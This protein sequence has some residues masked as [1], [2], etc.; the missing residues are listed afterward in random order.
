MENIEKYNNAFMEVF[1]V[2]AERLND[3]FVNKNVDNWDSVHHLA[4]CSMVEESFDIMLDT[5]DLLA[6]TSYVK[7]KEILKKYDINL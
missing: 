5:E 7:G 1:S 3:D 6:F 2:E 4:L